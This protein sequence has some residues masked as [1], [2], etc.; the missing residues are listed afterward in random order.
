[1]VPNTKYIAQLIYVGWFFNVIEWIGKFM[2]SQNS[3]TRKHLCNNWTHPAN[4]TNQEFEAQK[5]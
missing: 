5:G 2:E 1:M 3:T 4:A